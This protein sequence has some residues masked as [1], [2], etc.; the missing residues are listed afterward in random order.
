MRKGGLFNNVV[1]W[2]PAAQS[3]AQE[4]I[5]EARLSSDSKAKELIL[6]YAN[7]LHFMKNLRAAQQAT[8]WTMDEIIRIA[9]HE[10]FK[11]SPAA[12]GMTVFEKIEYTNDAMV[13][14][15]KLPKETKRWLNKIFFVP[16]YRIGNF[17]FF[18]SQLAKHPNRF[19]GPIARTFG[20]KMFVKY[21]LP[22][23]VTSILVAMGSRKRAYSE[24]GYK[25]VIFNPDTNT[26]TVY[27][28][29]GPLLEGQKLTQRNLRQSF[30]FNLAALPHLGY[31][32]LTG[33]RSGQ[34]DDVIGEF[35]KLG[36][37]IWRDIVTAKG[38]DRKPVEKV[39][40]LMALAYT[41][42]RQ[43]KEKI[44]DDAVQSTLKM[45]S[46]W[47]DW[48]EQ[49]EDI[50][51]MVQGKTGYFGPGGE[52][53][54]L[55]RQFEVKKSRSQGKIDKEITRMFR[56]GDDREALEYAFNEKRFKSVG[57]FS[58]R[59]VRA[60]APLVYFWETMPPIEQAEFLMFLKDSGYDIDTSK[61]KSIKTI[62]DALPQDM[63]DYMEQQIIN[64]RNSRG[65]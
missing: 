55:L 10:A 31:R 50:K 37:P 62:K 43:H 32:I 29:G 56:Q 45:L 64:L 15:A 7:P 54:K 52:F 9:A 63:R 39:L 16:N 34:T 12:Q 36:T 1:N 44:D 61:V 40:T 17:R 6:K 59:Y 65:K 19:K 33:P 53:D 8:T 24:K 60:H 25:M 13:N 41:Y 47:T 38:K 30:D 20:W 51:R 22:A 18:W 23:M 14:Y 28:I 5:D 27:S 4:M 26:D 58:G 42:Q 3:L 11:D 21:G 57:G 46:V 48:R 49:G 2:V 35:F